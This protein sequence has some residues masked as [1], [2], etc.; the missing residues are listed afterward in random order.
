MLQSWYEKTFTGEENFLIKKFETRFV[1]LIA[2][3]IIHGS[4]NY[5]DEQNKNFGLGETQFSAP[6]ANK[7]PVRFAQSRFLLRGLTCL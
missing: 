6:A 3:N 5:A 1:A 4:T 2:E 7:Q